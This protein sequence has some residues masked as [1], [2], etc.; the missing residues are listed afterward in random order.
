M[1]Y[2]SIVLLFLIGCKQSSPTKAIAASQ[3]DHNNYVPLP[4]KKEPTDKEKIA[5]LRVEAHKRHITW[6]IFCTEQG[7]QGGAWPTG[8]I[9]PIDPYHP[10]TYEDGATDGWVEQG[11]TQA[12]TAYK[13]YISIQQI[14]NWHPGHR[15]R[16][17]T[18]KTKICPPELRGQ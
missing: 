8:T 15:E 6:V 5:L 16:E 10:F 12:N 14:P 2:L 1:K 9:S 11:D 3:M 18:N 17:K 7:F 13:L 4:V